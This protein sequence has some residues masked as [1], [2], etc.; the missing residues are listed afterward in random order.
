MSNEQN[1]TEQNRTEQN[2]TEQ[3][4]T[5]QRRFDLNSEAGIIS[6]IA[7]GI[8][9]LMIYFGLLIQ[10]S[11]INT[12]N[13]IRNSNNYASARHIANSANEYLLFLLGKHEAGYNFSDAA[14]GGFVTCNYVG[15]GTYVADGSACDEFSGL[16][17]EK[18]I[19]I[20]MEIKARA[21]ATENLRTTKCRVGFS[22]ISNECYAVPFPGTGSANEDCKMYDPV[23][24]TAGDANIP[25]NL[26]GSAGIVDQLDYSCN[27]NKLQFG[28]SAID[29]TSIPLYYESGL[30]GDGNSIIVNPFK[31]GL[32]DTIGLRIRTPCKCGKPLAD[33][34]MPSG[35][36][37]CRGGQD[38]TVCTDNQRYVLNDGRASTDTDDIVVQWQI[39]GKCG[40]EE[41]GLMGYPDINSAIYEKIINDTL[42]TGNYIV[43]Y[44]ESRGAETDTDNYDTSAT[45]KL[46][47]KLIL[48]EKPILSIFLSHPLFDE[49]GKIIPYLEYQLITDHPVSNPTN[50]LYSRA[51]VDGNNFI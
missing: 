44:N 40:G 50:R 10:Q 27:W 19:M 31:D 16:V 36:F 33:G 18:D 3:N 6:V 11:T 30:D 26:T 1:R 8:F 37:D 4:R 48:M 21:A 28:S 5:E 15:G 51:R 7:L 32:A 47:N 23:F 9:A 41:C 42:T 46:L 20:E 49:D 43:L 35:E 12:Y 2:R 13:D 39:N 17:R 29:R 38:E 25:A 24:G 34:T 22:D 45:P 14:T